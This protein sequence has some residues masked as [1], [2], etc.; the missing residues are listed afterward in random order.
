M[1]RLKRVIF[2]RNIGNYS[3]ICRRNE[4]LPFAFP[5]SQKSHMFPLEER[6]MSQIGVFSASRNDPMDAQEFFAGIL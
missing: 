2:D 1:K 3:D 4:Y 5:V 6:D